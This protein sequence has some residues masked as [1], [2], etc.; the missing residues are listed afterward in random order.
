[1]TNIQSKL[2]LI[3]V[4]LSIEVTLVYLSI[5]CIASIDYPFSYINGTYFI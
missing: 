3:F 4:N 2:L 1:M 5:A